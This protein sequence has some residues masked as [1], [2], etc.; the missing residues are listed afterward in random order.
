MAGLTKTLLRLG[1]CLALGP[2]FSLASAAVVLQVSGGKLTGALNVEVQG[3]L[4]DVAF[5][6]GTCA[7]VFSGCNEPSDFAFSLTDT[8]AIHAAGALYAQ[9]LVNSGEGNFD[10]QPELTAGCSD[11]ANCRVLIPYS[12]TADGSF[13]DAI[14][15]FNQ[16]SEAADVIGSIDFPVTYDTTGV[17]FEVWAVF[18]PAA[19]VSEP[20]ILLLFSVSLAG[21]GLSRRRR[22]TNP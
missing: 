16:V 3:S 13:V 18:T 4:Y 21:L 6:D 10:S 20:G 17:S 14:G 8:P 22:A 11:I 2:A 19:A 12:V 9:V 15:A 7:S 1:L 5:V